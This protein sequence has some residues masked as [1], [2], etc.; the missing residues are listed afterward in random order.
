MTAMLHH[1][2]L[3]TVMSLSASPVPSS[4]KRVAEVLAEYRTYRQMTPKPVAVEPV[5]AAACTMFRHTADPH[6]DTLI[7]V[8]MNPPAADAFLQ[9]LEFPVGAVVVKRKQD[10]RGNSQAVGGMI[11]RES[12]FDPAN[13]DWEYFYAPAGQAAVTER[14]GGCAD[15][16]SRARE[17]DHV[18]GDWA[19]TTP[20]FQP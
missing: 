1:L 6:T 5:L 2:M 8:F 9:R 18:F 12:G 19:S 15:C 16:H 11:K 10:A 20:M 17:T 7:A 3:A 14:A 4:Q 13:G